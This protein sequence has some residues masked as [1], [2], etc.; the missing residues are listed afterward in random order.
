MAMLGNS[1]NSHTGNQPPAD[2]MAQS[3][4][5]AYTHMM[6]Q[7]ADASMKHIP[8]DTTYFNGMGAV[9]SSSRAYDA[10]RDSVFMLAA[11]RR[12]SSAWSASTH[13]S[14]Y[15]NER[16]LTLLGGQLKSIALDTIGNFYERLATL[17]PFIE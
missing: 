15:L 7:P 11:K 5:F 3:D 8:H 17:K 14:L 10:R 16:R 9:N 4:V 1:D 6:T 13:H 12:V 2:S